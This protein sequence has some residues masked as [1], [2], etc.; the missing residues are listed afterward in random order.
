MCRDDTRFRYLADAKYSTS[1]TLLRLE[2]NNSANTGN[3]ILPHLYLRFSGII[4]QPHKAV[5]TTQG[6]IVTGQPHGRGNLFSKAKTGQALIYPVKLASMKQD[7][8]YKRGKL[9]GGGSEIQTLMEES[10]EKPSQLTFA[11]P[12]TGV[13]KIGS[14]Q[15]INTQDSSCSTTFKQI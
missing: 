14:L 5:C 2:E 11:L 3:Q 10:T 8:E 1:H 9:Y 15:P 7:D 6:N 12:N 13:V 4:S